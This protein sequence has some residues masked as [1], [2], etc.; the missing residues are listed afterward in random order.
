[1][2]IVGVIAGA[3]AAWN[4]VTRKDTKEDFVFL[5]QSSFECL[6]V[7]GTIPINPS[8]AEVIARVPQ[9]EQNLDRLSRHSRNF[10]PIA[11]QYSEY[12][13]KLETLK[14]NG[15]QLS[16]IVFGLAQAVLG[17]FTHQNEQVAKGGDKALQGAE[18]AV[19]TFT[20]FFA[21]LNQKHIIATELADLTPK[22]SGQ[23]TDGSFLECS[24]SEHLP[25]DFWKLDKR[26]HL[27]LVNSSGR[28][29]TNCVVS[30]RLSNGMGPPYVNY[31]FV[32][33]W[34]TMKAAPHIIQFSI[35]LQ[36]GLIIFQG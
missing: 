11:R 14:S 18:N 22:F 25:T 24:F 10:A 36:I 33:N 7:D 2:A 12:I 28:D 19:K 16:P 5:C 4:A 35:Y 31:Y 27:H 26:Q 17:G 6:P 20:E 3:I 21:T 29:L 23:I 32:E 13:G 34:K 1:M 9:L 15:M 8:E 30:V